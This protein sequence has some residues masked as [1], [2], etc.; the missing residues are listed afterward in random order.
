M[1]TEADTDVADE[2]TTSKWSPGRQH[3]W[4]TTGVATIGAIAAATTLVMNFFYH[5]AAPP[6]TI[7]SSH[8]EFSKLSYSDRIDRCAPFINAHL[9][10]WQNRWRTDLSESGGSL[11]KDPVP[12]ASPSEATASGQAIVNTHTA[13]VNY[14]EKMADAD[15]GE[16]LLSCVYS[17]GLK[18]GAGQSYPDLESLVGNGNAVP[19]ADNIVVRESPVYYQGEFAGVTAEGRPSKIL[20]VIV[21]PGPNENHREL[22]FIMVSG[23]D[24]GVRMW[25]LAAQVEPNEAPWLPDVQNY[26]GF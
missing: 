21:R 8:A 20:E 15:Q 3:W 9:G 22:G 16:N 12:F 1:A 11:Q 23:H 10:E 19:K 24:R 17:P 2:V 14:A 6:V 25:V 5:P 4:L 13:V 26:K 18:V 7:D